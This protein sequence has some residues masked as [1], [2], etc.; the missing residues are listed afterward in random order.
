[1]SKPP[2]RTRPFALASLLSVLSLTLLADSRLALAEDEPLRAD[3]TRADAIAAVRLIRAECVACHGADRQ[4]GGLRLDRRDAALSGGES[5]AAIEP[6][7]ADRSLLFRSVSGDDAVAEMPPKKPLDPARIELLRRWIDS[8]AVWIEADDR[9]G[10]SAP[11]R[12]D[13]LATERDAWTDPSNPVVGRFGPERL[14]LWSLEPMRRE[15]LPIV[16]SG[17]A[18]SP[19]DRWIE[20]RRNEAGIVDGPEADRRTLLRRLS[21]DLTGLPPDV[22]AIERFVLD[23]RP[24]AWE[25]EVDRLLAS[26]RH[27]EHVARAWLD[28]ARYSDSNGFDWDEFRPEAYRYRDWVVDA[29]DRD[30]PYDRFVR[31]QLA[32]DELV[33]PD[34]ATRDDLGAWIATGFLRLGPH[35]NAAK[36]FDEQDRSRAEL[37]QDLVETTAAAFLGQTFSCCRCH[38][39]K[40]EPLLQADHYRLR[41]FFEGV[42]FVDDRP[43]ETID[44][45]LERERLTERIDQELAALEAERGTLLE[46]LRSARRAASPMPGSE[47]NAT[48]T[49]DARAAGGETGEMPEESKESEEPND[50]ELI[51]AADPATR[52]RFAAFDAERSHLESLRPRPETAMR[53]SESDEPIGPTFVLYQGD[54]QA[55][56]DEV[57]PGF[58]SLWDPTGAEIHK[59]TAGTTSGRRS[60]LADWIVRPDHPWTWRVAANRVWQGFFGRGLVA[61]PNDFGFSG[62]RPTH[63]QLLD[64]LALDLVDGGGSLKLLRRRIVTS[65]VYRQ[66]GSRVESEAERRRQELA[67]ERDPEGTLYWRFP[68]RR[69]T[70]EQLRDAM[71]VSVDGLDGRRGGPA[72]WPELPAE[73]LQANPAFLDDNAEKT[74]GWYPSPIERRRVRSL[75]WVQKR[76]VRIPFLETFDLPENGTSCAMRGVSIVPPQA[77][78]LLN[79]ELTDE[80]AALASRRIEAERIVDRRATIVQAYRWLLQREPTD[81]ELAACLSF[82]ERRSTDEL[83]RALLNTAEFATIE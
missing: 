30:L 10:A 52:E 45:R 38:D 81:D 36:L 37:M 51:A 5:G 60:T 16:D 82:L 75:Y 29:F 33:G 71:L 22:E 77:F 70:A 7:S 68:S 26:A 18:R 6:G 44:E 4:E 62:E 48:E 20:V 64:H 41:A 11:L 67:W 74:K 14:R 1:M 46:S 34:P 23:E 58:P 65:A 57:V 31:E 79:G 13:P 35:D 50:D 49:D 61:T 76:T 25:R 28:V 59:P 39:H 66:I 21:F 15:P 9:L 42:A 32:G 43:L 78:T 53:M 3:S 69:L 2:R 40:T 12:D 47:A 19:I 56:R 80:V 17:W 27:G 63:P 73:I 83:I 55:P 8:G 24:D 72:V 54:H